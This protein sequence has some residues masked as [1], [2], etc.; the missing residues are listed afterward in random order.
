MTVKELI[1]ELQ[2]LNPELTVIYSTMEDNYE[3][4]PSINKYDFNTSYYTGK[5]FITIP[6]NTEFVSL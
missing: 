1:E 3:P 5:E 4:G 2:K 6:K